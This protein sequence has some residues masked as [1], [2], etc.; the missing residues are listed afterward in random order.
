MVTR[1]NELVAR[2]NIAV[3][4]CRFEST[5]IDLVTAMK[6]TIA[7]HY[8]S[9]LH[10]G[11]LNALEHKVN[12]VVLNNLIER[13]NALLTESGDSA[14]N[15]SITMELNILMRDAVN[16]YNTA[17]LT[18]SD[19][20]GLEIAINDFQ[21]W[22]KEQ[23][24]DLR[25]NDEGED[26]KPLKTAPMDDVNSNSLTSSEVTDSSLT[27]DINRKFAQDVNTFLDFIG[28]ETYTYKDTMVN[29]CEEISTYVPWSILLERD[30]YTF[31]YLGAKSENRYV[32][33]T[34]SEVKG[35]YTRLVDVINVRLRF[36]GLEVRAK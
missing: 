5:K 12:V 22:V 27:K 34:P 33:L 15:D 32:D 9:L 26:V 30:R 14:Y 7:L 11:A 29:L 31:I 16:L 2:G 28:C 6:D 23:N 19:L 24:D 25:C 3:E 21:A 18:E 1:L 8:S 10:I 20:N 13:G 35:L 36:I 17:E 4:V